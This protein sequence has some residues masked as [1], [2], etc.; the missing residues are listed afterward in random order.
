YGTSRPVSWGKRAI[1]GGPCGPAA[2]RLPRSAAHFSSSRSPTAMRQPVMRVPQFLTDENVPFETVLHPPTYTAARRARLLG[3]S[4]RGLAKCVL[5]RGPD[6]H[7]LAIVPATGRVN[8]DAAARALGGP[9][10][11]AQPAEIPFVFGDCEWGT[12][13]PFGTLYGVPTLLDESFDP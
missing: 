12:L 3:V 4:G 7:A 11:L 5:L 9:V 10:R 13:V 2:V 1:Y 8:L 6:G